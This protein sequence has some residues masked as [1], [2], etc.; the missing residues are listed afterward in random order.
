MKKSLI[1]RKGFSLV[2]LLVALLIMA[3]I[4][5]TAI[6]LFAGVLESTRGGADR[7]KANSIKNAILA[8][9][10]AANDLNL[11]ALGV[12]DG[13][14]AQDLVDQLTGIIVISTSGATRT[15]VI[16]GTNIAIS[17][18]TVDSEELDGTYG[19]FLDKTDVVP[20]QS[21]NLGWKIAID[22]L[23]RVVTV[24]VVDSVD[25]ILSIN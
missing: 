11:S 18:G 4:A 6:T 24:E 21:G 9:M 5:G 16:T 13:D 14:A 10:Y 22:T 1:N 17:S 7:D 8:Y 20:E 23:Y 19:P 15:S 12:A 25:A 2:E 3:I